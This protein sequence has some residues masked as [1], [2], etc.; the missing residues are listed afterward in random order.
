MSQPIDAAPKDGSLILLEDDASGAYDVA[1]WSPETA[2]WIGKNG[3]PSKITGSHW[4]PIPSE[5]WSKASAAP[6][7]V[8]RG[9]RSKFA[10]LAIASVVVACFVA[11][12]F[13][14]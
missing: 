5:T 11:V 9:L 2:T 14:L 13:P 8:P 10:I 12:P 7:Q 3:E 6:D 1:S 4:L